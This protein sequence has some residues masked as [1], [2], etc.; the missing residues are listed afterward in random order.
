MKARVD[1]QVGELTYYQSQNDFQIHYVPGK[2]IDCL[3]RN[4]VIESDNNTE[5][6]L[7]IINLVQIDEIR[8]DHENNSTLQRIKAKLIV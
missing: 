7:K 8:I 3:S 4:P 6:I 5:D 1:E 2:D